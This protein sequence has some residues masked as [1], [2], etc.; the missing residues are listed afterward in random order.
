MKGTEKQIAWAADIQSKTIAAMEAARNQLE[1]QHPGV[2]DTVINYIR[3]AEFASDLIEVFG[4]SRTF[5]ARKVLGCIRITA[6]T[7]IYDK[8]AFAAVKT[9]WKR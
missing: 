6:D 8:K 1:A 3:N 7:N 4:G 5:D 9:V 2:C